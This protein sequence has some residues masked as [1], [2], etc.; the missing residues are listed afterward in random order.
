M[1]GWRLSFTDNGVSIHV[2][3]IKFSVGLHQACCNR[4]RYEEYTSTLRDRKTQ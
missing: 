2:T 4:T 3:T 1:H